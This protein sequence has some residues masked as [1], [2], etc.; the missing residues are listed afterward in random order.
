LQKVK[1]FS[2]GLANWPYFGMLVI[3]LASLILHIA[4]ITTPLNETIF[5]EVHYVTDG[6]RIINGEGSQRNEHPPLARLIIAESM[7]YIGDNAWGWRTPSVVMSTIGLI[8][9]Y[10]IC[11]SLSKSHRIS[12]LATL[13]LAFENLYFIHGDMAMLDEYVIFFSIA[14]FWLYLKGPL[15]WWAS[16]IVGAMAALSKFTGM[17]VF[18]PIGLHWLYSEREG[19]IAI[20]TAP[21]RRKEIV[22]P[23]L[24][25]AAAPIAMETTAPYLTVEGETL[26]VPVEAP[27]PPPVSPALR[28]ARRGLIFVASMLL[29]PV[30]FLLLYAV[31]DRIIW[32]RWIDIFADIRSALTGT[33]S[34]KFSYEGAYPSRPWEWYLSPINAFSIWQWLFSGGQVPVK[35]LGYD[36]PP[37]GPH[38]TGMVSPTIWLVSLASVP[39]VIWSAMKRRLWFILPVVWFVGVGVVP[40]VAIA[41]MSLVPAAIVSVL[42]FALVIPLILF[43]KK[44][45]EW[46]NTMAFVF[47]WLVG[48][49]AVWIPLAILTNRITYSFYY[50][51]TVPALCLAAALLF[52]K[53]FDAAEGKHN[54]DFRGFIRGSIAFFIFLH[55]VIFCLLAPDKLS[56]SIPASILI[57]AFSLDFLGYSWQT[58]FSSVAAVTGGVLFLRYALYRYLE[59]WFGTATIVGLYPASIWFWVVGT[60]ASLV[61]AAIILVVLR[62]WVLRSKKSEPPPVAV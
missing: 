12:F 49:W 55:L 23:A 38:I 57:L 18:V 9:F 61:V 22:A 6:R 45:G 53:L 29:A 34:I 27:G 60:A 59:Q 17:F 52:K 39:W 62:R 21:F 40:T 37:Y 47:F 10:G 42:W 33:D 7:K 24:P 36:W 54:R 56:I 25:E 19:L 35:L 4:V 50:L 5:D 31:C 16:A 48:T 15:W 3:V 26:P 1:R 51:P 46:S 11:M 28:T 8:M 44:N 58:M 30:T 13:L 14:A 2:V 43:M 20:L 32:N 41:H